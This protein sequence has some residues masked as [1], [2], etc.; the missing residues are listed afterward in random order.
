MPFRL[1]RFLTISLAAL[2]SLCLYCGTARATY[3]DDPDALG[4]AVSVLRS[5]VG[6][7]ARVFRVE[8]ERE[9]ITIEIQ[10]PGNR[11]HIDSW[12]YGVVRFLRIPTNRLSGP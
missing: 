9:A 12:R 10:D 3:L 2:C 4:L 5:K 1:R 8:I 11:S 7:H 6:E